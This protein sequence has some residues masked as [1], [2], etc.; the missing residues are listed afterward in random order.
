MPPPPP[1]SMSSLYEAELLSTAGPWTVSAM[2]FSMSGRPKLME[3]GWPKGARRLIGL[4]LL[5]RPSFAERRP[6]CEGV[7]CSSVCGRASV[8]CGGV[9]ID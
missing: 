4:L 1:A 8:R 5:S 3:T 7:P 9:G 2:N 6:W